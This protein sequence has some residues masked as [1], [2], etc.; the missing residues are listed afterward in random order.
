MVA[1]GAGHRRDAGADAGHHRVAVPRVADRV[2]HHL[3]QPQ[4]AVGGEQQHP[5][6]ERGGDAGG[7]Q[8]AAGHQVQP[9]RRERLH[10]GGLRRWP[11]AVQHEDLAPAGVVADDRHLAAGPVQV[12]LDDLQHQA[13][14]DRRVERVPALLQHGHA[15][16][17]GEPV[18][19]GHHA[20]RARQLRPGG[21]G[22]PLWHHAHS[23]GGRPGAGQSHATS[24]AAIAGSGHRLGHDTVTP[25]TDDLFPRLRAV[26]DLD[27]AEMREGAGRHEYDGVIQD[28][29]PEGVRAGLAA[30]AQAAESGDPL[31]DAHDEAHLATFED[32]AR[33]SLGELEL[34]RRNPLY[35]LFGL[36]LAGYDREYAPPAER[37][38]ARLAHLS[39]WPEAVDAA[40]AAL[41]QVSAPVAG[42]LLDGIKGLAAGIPADAP[43]A[44][45]DAARAAH[46]RL[47]AAVD[48]HGRVR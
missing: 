24:A 15:R 29:S 17:G 48:R 6:P 4:P 46:E 40:V 31:D 35:H 38:R 47:V 23:S 25:M 7:E 8:P 22:G 16:R 42:A 12:R 39:R 34:H 1:E 14:R 28:M 9:E 5:G 11:L 32:H 27:V 30:L 44:V 37:D 19:G 21:E 33:V 13:R 41:D 3:A 20:E 43:E 2:L 10:G 36:D 18:G 26:C 45:A